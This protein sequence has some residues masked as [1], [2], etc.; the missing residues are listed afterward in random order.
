MLAVGI[1][2]WCSLNFYYL[3]YKY[4]R[5][6]SLCFYVISTETDECVSTAPR[7]SRPSFNGAEMRQPSPV[8]AR[9][10]SLPDGER[11]KTGMSS[12]MESGTWHI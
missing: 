6:I 5:R 7:R 10:V 9:A 3:V 11:N 1:C 12:A 2:I 4:L 8:P